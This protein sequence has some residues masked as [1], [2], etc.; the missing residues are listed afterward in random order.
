[1]LSV[2]LSTN[3]Y[4]LTDFHSVSPSTHGTAKQASGAQCD[5]IFK[6]KSWLNVIQYN[7]ENAMIISTMEI[8][9]CIQVVGLNSILKDDNVDCVSGVLLLLFLMSCLRS[10]ST[11]SR[12]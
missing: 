9:Q 5:S 7:I 6:S 12:A 4:F 3:I 8:D 1:M 10:L 2:C 11:F